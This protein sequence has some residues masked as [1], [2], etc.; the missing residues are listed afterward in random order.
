MAAFGKMA[1]VMGHGGM[2]VENNIAVV[3]QNT[4]PNLPTT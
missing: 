2:M 3:V 4:A 1:V